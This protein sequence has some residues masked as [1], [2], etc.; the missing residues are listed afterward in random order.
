MT[1]YGPWDG[2]VGTRYSTLP[3]P[4]HPHYP[5]YTLPLARQ[6]EDGCTRC[7]ASRNMAVGLISV[8]QLTLDS[9]FSGSLGMTEVYN[10][11]YIG[12]INNHSFIPGKEKAGVSNPWTRP[13]I[14]QQP[15]MKL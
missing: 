10:L 8:D 3:P 5:G 9:R 7:P 15:S 6:Y 13:S 2:W 12:R 11:R 4:T 1:K 14:C